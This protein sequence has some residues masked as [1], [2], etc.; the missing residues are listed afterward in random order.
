MRHASV[1]PLEIAVV[2]N[3]IQTSSSA[4][5]VI[6][7]STASAG[8]LRSCSPV[9]MSRKMCPGASAKRVDTPTLASSEAISTVVSSQSPVCRASVSY[10]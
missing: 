5:T 6:P 9:S 4:I 8:R 1:N 10:G 2:S 7:S 3:G